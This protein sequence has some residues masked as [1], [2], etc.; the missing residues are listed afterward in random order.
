MK[1][2][3]ESYNREISNTNREK[4]CKEDKRFLKER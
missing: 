4:I 3:K 2:L 1:R